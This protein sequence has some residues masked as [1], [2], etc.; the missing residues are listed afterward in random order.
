MLG[1]ALPNPYLPPSNHNNPINRK[2]YSMITMKP[3][4]IAARDRRKAAI[5]EAGLMIIGGHIGLGS[6]NA[7]LEKTSNP[8]LFDKFWVGH[9]RFSN[10]DRKMPRKKIALFAV[11]GA[12]AECCWQRYT[13]QDTCGDDFWWGEDAMSAS[14]WAASGCEPGNPTRQLFKTIETAF[15]LLDREAGLLWPAL[16]SEARHLIVD[17]RE[18]DIY[19]GP[20]PAKGD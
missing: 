1:C 5:H 15:S 17:S 4:R 20:A 10:F 19:R 7:W 11:A 12:V 18:T 16:T 13:F 3:G 6:I 2:A 14:D 9:T 8:G